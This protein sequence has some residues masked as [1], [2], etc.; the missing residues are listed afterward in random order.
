LVDASSS[1]D[2][3]RNLLL[4]LRELLRKEKTMQPC[5]ND[6]E[7]REPASSMTK[8]TRRWPDLCFFGVVVVSIL[9]TQASGKLTSTIIFLGLSI[10]MVQVQAQKKKKLPF[11]P[12]KPFV[13]YVLFA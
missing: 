9:V 3:S 1:G 8:A 11:P 6:D 7:L 10:V 5:N 13:F 2:S 4:F 12:N